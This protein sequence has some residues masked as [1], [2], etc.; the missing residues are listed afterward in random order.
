MK[1]RYMWAVA[2]GV[3]AVG[4]WLAKS[5]VSPVPDRQS[6]VQSSPSGPP[7]VGAPPA[8]PSAPPAAVPNVETPRAPSAPAA[9]TTRPPAEPQRPPTGPVIPLEPRAEPAAPVTPPESP[10]PPAPVTAP[11]PPAPPPVA[12]EE[13]PKAPTV[14]PPAAVP[15]IVPTPPVTAG[16]PAVRNPEFAAVEQLVT[17]YS[18]IYRQ[19]DANAVATIWPS[20]NTSQLSRLFARIQRQDLTFDSCVFA[21]VESRATATCNGSLTYVPRV[22][23]PQPRTER[24]VWTIQLERS[25]GGWLIAGINAR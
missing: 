13:R 11:E 4:V 17:R 15:E 22:G 18:T 16:A 19:L 6:P 2:V 5:L 21:V 7:A 10:G 23:N 3:L 25:A 1:N 20:V 12:L 8:E 14:P 24:H 9:P